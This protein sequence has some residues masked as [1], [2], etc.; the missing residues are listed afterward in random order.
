MT[1]RSVFN[2]RVNTYTCFP[3]WQRYLGVKMFISFRNARMPIMYMCINSTGSEIIHSRCIYLHTYIF[4][5]FCL[6]LRRRLC[7][8]TAFHLSTSA[9]RAAVYSHST[10]TSANACMCPESSSTHV[11][12]VAAACVLLWPRITARSLGLNRRGKSFPCTLY[13]LF[14]IIFATNIIIIRY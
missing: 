6:W 5:T 14:N 11:I 3:T 1:T 8:A 4:L 12:V 7:G 13:V 9:P 2:V 10:Y